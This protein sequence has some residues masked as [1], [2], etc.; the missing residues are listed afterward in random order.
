M[1][2]CRCQELIFSTHSGEGTEVLNCLGLFSKI[3][4]E[5]KLNYEL[6]VP[7]KRE[8]VVDVTLI[9]LFFIEFSNYNTSIL[10]YVAIRSKEKN[11]FVFLCL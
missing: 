3:I 10:L 6:T 1:S 4:A 7:Q 9:L 11:V 5:T 2:H 8:E